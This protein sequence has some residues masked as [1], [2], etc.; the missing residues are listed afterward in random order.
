[1][2]WDEELCELFGIPVEVLPEIKDSNA[3]FGYTDLDGYLEH[4]IPIYGVLGDSHAALFGQGC[5][6]R[7]MVKATYGT[8]SSIMMNIGNQYVESKN[9][10]ATSLAWRMNGKAEYVLEGNINYAGA[11]ITW[12]QDDVHLVESIKELEECVISANAQDTTVLVPAFSGLGAPY[13]NGNAKAMLY[14][15]T[16]TTGQAE[17]AKAAVESIAFQVA[18][19][20][21]A[22]KEDSQSQM[23]E[24]RV[25]GGPTKN[26]YLM[27][28]QSGITNTH[29]S[30]ANQEE[31][32]AIGSA[33]MA[34]ISAGIYDK[35]K[36][37]KN[38]AYDIYKPD[39]EEIVRARKKSQWQEAVEMI[40][41]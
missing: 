2:S 3:N 30:V 37:F 17:I 41:K 27:K 38:V 20:L 1:L 24:L 15:M 6:K 18:D 39:M 32:S 14:G 21:E 36:V 29:I 12:L 25:D 19:I 13:W 26:K 23:K 33:Y 11:V 4:Q 28:F 40:L 5:H 16:R 8:G 10:L 22:M 34:G 9:G 31:L 7:G 35:E